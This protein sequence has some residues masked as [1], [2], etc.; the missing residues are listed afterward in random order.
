M[1]VFPATG[2]T[3]TSSYLSKIFALGFYCISRVNADVFQVSSV[4]TTH[5]HSMPQITQETGNSPVHLPNVGH[6][7]QRHIGESCGSTSG[8]SLACLFVCLFVC[9]ATFSVPTSIQHEQKAADVSSLFCVMR[10]GSAQFWLIHL[11]RFT[12]IKTKNAKNKTKPQNLTASH[13]T[14]ILSSMPIYC[15]CTL[16]QKTISTPGVI[17]RLTKGSISLD[18]TGGRDTSCTSLASAANPVF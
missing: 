6:W 12:T 13:C 9:V 17:D 5:T 18:W 14:E 3:N 1:I 8:A 10:H 2:I 4:C 7:S 11:I 15:M 16:P